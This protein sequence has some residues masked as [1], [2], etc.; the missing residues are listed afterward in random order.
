MNITKLKELLITIR[1]MVIIL[2]FLLLLIAPSF[3]KAR[4]VAAGFTKLDMGIA[5][6]EAELKQSKENLELA[7]H[8]VVKM[9]NE[10]TK[11][12][13]AIEKHSESESQGL[14][15]NNQDL[16]DMKIQIDSSANQL[17]AVDS[18]LQRSINRQD[19]LMKKLR[20]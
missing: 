6:W 4:L 7:E 19:L 3:V 1:E 12:S 16:M 2:I 5:E 10:L 11:I 17:K 18:Q 9:Q 20:N 13:S 8:K 15:S 14:K